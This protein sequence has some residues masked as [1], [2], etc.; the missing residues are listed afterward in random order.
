MEDEQPH[1]ELGPLLTEQ[2]MERARAFLRQQGLFL[3]DDQ[4]LAHIR[5]PSDQRQCP[6]R[7]GFE[8][9]VIFC[10]NQCHLENV[11][12]AAGSERP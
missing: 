9:G 2:E 4:I 5:V 7:Y 11:A 8:G 3:P 1:C 6:F 10:A 12:R